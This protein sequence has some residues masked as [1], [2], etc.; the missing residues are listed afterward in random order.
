MRIPALND[1][2]YVDVECHYSPEFTS[3][4][5]SNC[6]LLKTAAKPSDYKGQS[7]HTYFDV[8]DEELMKD[9]KNGTT[10]L[11]KDYNMEN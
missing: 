9:L 2:G 1:V 8:N 4:L 10:S 11:D 6:D 3:T 5:L 7:I